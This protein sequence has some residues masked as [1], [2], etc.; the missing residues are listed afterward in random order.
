MENYCKWC[1]KS[2]RKRAWF[3]IKWK[4]Q[5]SHVVIHGAIDKDLSYRVIFSG[6]IAETGED[7][8]AIYFW[9]KKCWDRTKFQSFA[10]WRI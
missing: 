9:F 7:V 6:K 3:G 2:W 4:I 5:D 10:I 1:V 8:F